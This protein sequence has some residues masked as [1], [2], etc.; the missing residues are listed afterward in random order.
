[1]GGQ[2]DPVLVIRGT[3]KFRD[4]VPATAQPSDAASTTQL[5]DWYVNAH[6]WR[7]HMAILVNERTFLPVALPLAPAASVLNRI[8]DAITAVLSALGVDADFIEREGM[9]MDTQL[10]LPTASKSVLGVMK[11]LTDI[12]RMYV[13]YD[14]ITDPVALSLRMAQIPT[15][16]LF[17]RHVSPDREVIAYSH[18]LQ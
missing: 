15:G 3:K 8:P 16:P 9:A 1:M 6:F 11:G 12:G 2:T 14:R 17:T 7:P 10:L 4:R 5:G 18:A 13:T